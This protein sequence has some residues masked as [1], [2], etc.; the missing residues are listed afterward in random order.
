MYLSRRGQDI[1]KK[2]SDYICD[3]SDASDNKGTYVGTYIHYY[4]FK[5]IY[6]NV[7]INQLKYAFFGVVCH[8]IKYP[9]VVFGKTS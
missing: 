3:N 2:V 4:V 8:R 6:I 1:I 9:A 5:R 7:G